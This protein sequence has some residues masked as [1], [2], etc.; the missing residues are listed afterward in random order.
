MK[1]LVLGGGGFIGYHL[2]EDLMVAGHQVT[3]L[4]RS[5]LPT[6]PLPVGVEYVS[7]DLAD[8][9]LIRELLADV[10]A[11]AHLVSGT[12]PSTGDK[13]PGRDVEL[14]LLG[15]L[16]LLEDM[17]ASHVTRILYLSSGGTVYGKPQEVPIPEGHILDPICSY[18]VV[19]VAIESYLK[20]YE[21]K[22]GLK[23][24]VIRA[25]NPYGLYQGNL[26]VQ[27][28]IGTYLNLA[29]KHQPIEIWG[30][31]SAIRDYIHVKDLSSLCV[32]ALLSDKVGVYNG[33]SGTGTSVLHI[34][35]IVQEITGSPIPI[36]YKPHR[37]LDVP[38]S[39]LDIERAKMDFD[40]EPK[41]G[42]RQGIA[43]VW[44]WLKEHQ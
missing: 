43:G 9:K 1:I 18:G 38:V 8:S 33:G 36:V 17:A 5:D 37:S 14:N 27:G 41:I 42:L 20:L 16:S 24:V 4:G 26:G 32:T 15:T 25:S 35:E 40:W 7:G 22:S 28:I 21:I 2:V 31:G 11:V 6:R 30:D 23:P 44:S 29:L 13:D 3:V 34:A 12:V 10:N 39:V 19:K